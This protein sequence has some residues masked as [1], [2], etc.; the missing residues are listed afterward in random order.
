VRLQL[1]LVTAPLRLGSVIGALALTT[2]CGRARA[3]PATAPDSLNTSSRPATAP[4]SA[5]ESSFTE[6]LAVD[7]GQY[8][9][10]DHV[11]VETPSIRGTVS[12]PT[13]GWSVGGQYLVDVVSAASVD[14]VSTASRR[15]QEV[16]Q[17]GSVE[18]SYEPKAFGVQANGTL[19]D[20]PD[21]V[22]WSGGG[23]ITQDL[24]NHNVTWLLGYAR[25]HDIAG[26]TGTSFSVFS[27]VVDRNAFKAA[28]TLVLSPTTVASLL[29]D[30]ILE[31][32]DQSKPYRYIPLFAAGTNVPRGA[33]IDL[34]NNLR[35]SARPL[36][37]LP[38]SR[39]RYGL[40]MRVAHRYHLATLRLDERLYVDS[41]AM[42]A[43]TTDARYL[44]DLSRRVE[45]GPHA[46]LH[47]QTAVDFWRR[48]YSFGPGFDYPALRTGDRELG[49][50]VNLTGGWT[51]RTGLGTDANPTSWVLGFDLNAT[52]TQY[53]DDLYLTRRV[54]AL[55]VVTLE[56]DL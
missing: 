51:L 35:V 56:T 44:F 1:A 49:P 7:Y 37:Q 23:A 30:L 5:R 31:N 32:G 22:S 47:A 55:G 18:A 11:F 34:V 21:Y 10:T 24:V 8:A 43:T 29:G 52:S 3:Q 17:E 42:K 6:H 53:L 41:W 48:A 12:D 4:A 27:R 38:L 28:L 19:S 9:D 50:L 54:S 25:G 15:W 40:T 16:R 36:E 39:Q 2:T 26:R 20:E 14:I 13:A 45:L 46:R 33:P